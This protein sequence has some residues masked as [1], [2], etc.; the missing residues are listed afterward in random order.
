MIKGGGE[1][2]DG[3]PPGAGVMRE[4]ASTF[5]EIVGVMREIAA[6]L[7]VPCCLAEFIL[8]LSALLNNIDSTSRGRRYYSRLDYYYYS[9]LH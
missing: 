2:G 8:I 3:P 6:T 1:R 9:I 7:T 4:I 5:L